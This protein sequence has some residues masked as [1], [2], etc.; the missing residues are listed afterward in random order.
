MRAV[1]ATTSSTEA[2]GW[3]QDHQKQREPSAAGP[4]RTRSF[5]VGVSGLATLTDG[6]APGRR[7]AVNSRAVNPS[8]RR[9]RWAIWSSA[10]LPMGHGRYEC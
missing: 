10:L 5:R 9:L 1:A 4:H 8:A 6:L 7:L 3:P 2:M